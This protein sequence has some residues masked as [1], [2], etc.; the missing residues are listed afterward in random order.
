MNTCVKAIAQYSWIATLALML[1][2]CGGGGGGSGGGPAA[3]GPNS[4]PVGSSACT[5][6]PD[7]VFPAFVYKAPVGNHSGP[8]VIGIA[9]SDGCRALPVVEVARQPHAEPTGTFR[10][11][12]G[13]LAWV[14]GGAREGFFAMDVDMV[15]FTVSGPPG[16]EVVQADDPTTVLASDALHWYSFVD[17]WQ[18]DTPQ[19]VA[20]RV[21]EPVGPAGVGFSLVLIDP[22]GD[23]VTELWGMREGDQFA[24]LE[25][26][27]AA[28]HNPYTADACVLPYS[29]VS[30]SGDGQRIYFGHSYSTS[31]PGYEAHSGTA[32]L[33]RKDPGAGCRAPL[34]DLG[35][36]WCGP[37][38]IHTDLSVD[39]RFPLKEP[40]WGGQVRRAAMAGVPDLIVT[41]HV[42]GRRSVEPQQNLR[43]VVLDADY[44]AA[45]HDDPA[46]IDPL[47]AEGRAWRHCLHAGTA[48]QDHAPGRRPD[49]ALDGDRVYYTGWDQPTLRTIRVFNPTGVPTD[50]D[51]H[52][53]GNAMFGRTLR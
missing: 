11:G 31:Q 50:G 36:G 10:D 28:G 6:E 4:P 18:G 44:C 12:A 46:Q 40:P 5:P 49:W 32:R 13:T 30:I 26:A 34:P 42:D 7:A 39:P 35:N 27:A 38:L 48:L 1:W 3:G 47:L 33:E 43:V 45:L 21:D 14:Q 2:G 16:S 9:S 29:T 37:E 17:A 15:H 24:C 22:V 8:W 23:Q 41:H 51:K 53:L 19:L 52:V 20:A 25:S